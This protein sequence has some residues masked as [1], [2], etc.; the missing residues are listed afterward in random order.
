MWE[1]YQIFNEQQP[2]LAKTP[3]AVW[4]A[5]V[6]TEDYRRGKGV[7]GGESDKAILYGN[8]AE[9]KAK[10]FARALELSKR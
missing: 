8:R 10:S 7:E 4:Q 9:A 1:R 5:V 6:E 3:W 2:R